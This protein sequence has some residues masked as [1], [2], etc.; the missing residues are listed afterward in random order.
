[1]RRITIDPTTTELILQCMGLLVDVYHD[2]Y[3]YK[4]VRNNMETVVFPLDVAAETVN[5]RDEA[6]VIKAESRLYSEGNYAHVLRGV[7]TSVYGVETLLYFTPVARTSKEEKEQNLRDSKFT[8]DARRVF[9][10]WNSIDYGYEEIVL[11]PSQVIDPDFPC[12]L[13]DVGFLLAIDHKKAVPLF[14]YGNGMCLY[15]YGGENIDDII[16]ENSEKYL[17][18][19]I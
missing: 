1:V 9:E 4:I 12:N 17:F 8:G 10:I 15:R 14:S 3:A 19:K 6:I 13:V 11:N 16:K 5:K 18:K 7:V 2:N